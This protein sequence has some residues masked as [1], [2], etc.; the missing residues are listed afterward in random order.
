MEKLIEELSNYKG[1]KKVKVIAFITRPDDCAKYPVPDNYMSGE[2]VVPPALIE[3]LK[4]V[5]W[6]DGDGNVWFPEGLCPAPVREMTET[7]ISQSV[8][9]R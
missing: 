3:E 9:T 7:F 1:E 2:S 5:G 4:S 6:S 8:P